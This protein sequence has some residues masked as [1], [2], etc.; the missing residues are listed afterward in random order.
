MEWKI[1]KVVIGTAL[2]LVFVSPQP[3]SAF[4]FKTSARDL[5][6]G[7]N[8]VKSRIH[9]LFNE[10][11]FK[12]VLPPRNPA[13]NTFAVASRVNI[14]TAEGPSDYEA[15]FLQNLQEFSQSTRETLV[16]IVRAFHEEQEKSKKEI[17]VLAEEVK[18]LRSEVEALKKGSAWS[19]SSAAS[20]APGA[21]ITE[22]VSNR[23]ATATPEIHPIIPLGD[24]SGLSEKEKSQAAEI[25]AAFLKTPNLNR[26]APDEQ[27][28]L[29]SKE[30]DKY[31]EKYKSEMEMKITAGWRTFED[32]KNFLQ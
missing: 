25:Y 1:K 28:Q 13:S 31:I 3:A 17:N 11:G 6:S 29:W 7:F 14:K 20:P 5:A 15:G 23:A 32:L 21:E 26:Y 4:E 27:H 8:S 30:I 22:A 2:L 19:A 16:K 9:S 18:R 12:A 24:T 10:A